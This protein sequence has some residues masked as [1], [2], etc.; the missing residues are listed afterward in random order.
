MGAELYAATGNTPGQ[1]YQETHKY[2]HWLI[3][4]YT[5]GLTSEKIDQAVQVVMAWTAAV[6]QALWD[7]HRQPQPQPQA[8]RA[9]SAQRAPRPPSESLSTVWWS[10]APAHPLGS[11]KGLLTPFCSEG[12]RGGRRW[13][14]GLGT[15]DLRPQ[16]QPQPL[17]QPLPQPQAVRLPSAKRVAGGP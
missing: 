14:H 1:M 13:P 16:P 12:R 11:C 2:L 8:V 15:W 6:R 4:S 9:P 3:R 10:A 7:R 5:E 17:P